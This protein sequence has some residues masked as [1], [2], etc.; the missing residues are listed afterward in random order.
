MKLDPEKN[1]RQFP[2]LAGGPGIGGQSPQRLGIA[3]PDRMAHAH[4]G[5]GQGLFPRRCM[6]VVDDSGKFLLVAVAQVVIQMQMISVLAQMLE[7]PANHACLDSSG[8][9]VYGKR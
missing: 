7:L 4:Q 2:L 5:P 1:L 8:G 9:H 3:A 6:L